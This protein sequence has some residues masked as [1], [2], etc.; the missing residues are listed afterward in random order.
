[1]RGLVRCKALPLRSD[2]GLSLERMEAHGKRQD[3]TSQKRKVRD[4]GPLWV[5]SLD[6]MDE[7]NRHMEGVKMNSAVK[8][9]VL[10][11]LIKFPK[12][13]LTDD[14]PEKFRGSKQSRHVEMIKQATDFINKTHGGNAVFAARLDRDEAGELVVDVFAAPKYEKVT[15]RGKPDETRTVWASATKF[16]K[17]LAERH[18]DE[19]QA[20][21]TESKGPLTGPRAVG[22]ALQSEFSDYFLRK[23]GVVLERKFKDDFYPDWLDPEAYKEEQARLQAMRLAGM[24][25]AER[26]LVVEGLE[27]REKA[28]Q[29]ILS[30]EAALAEGEE[31][32]K[33]RVAQVDRREAA[34]G[35]R[36]KANESEADRLVNLK[37]DLDHQKADQDATGRQ[38]ASGQIQLA[39]DRDNFEADKAHQFERI[40]WA[41]VEIIGATVEGREIDPEAMQILRP[42]RKAI[43]PTLE[44][45][46]S[47]IAGTKALIASLP[48]LRPRL[49][50]FAR[51]A[52]EDPRDDRGFGL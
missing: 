15:R 16:G 49:D 37:V 30:R 48:G 4:V 17:E 8:K 35:D 10:H 28:A 1:M 42:I 31:A 39:T 18:Q 13:T 34:V 25:L 32:L 3:G 24:Q 33:V 46:Q 52:P 20:R 51:S 23:N 45:L 50:P 40:S 21:H 47:W 27:G 26:E 7:Y 29:V 41:T 19:I 43:K 12:E 2:K 9:P 6:L 38:L 22:I 14:A 44:R 11:F 5:G 36:E